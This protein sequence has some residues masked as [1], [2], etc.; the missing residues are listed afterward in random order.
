MRNACWELPQWRG[1]GSRSD[2]QHLRGKHLPC[3]CNTS[4]ALTASLHSDWSMWLASLACWL[5]VNCGYPLLT[6]TTYMSTDCRKCKCVPPQSIRLPQ[7]FLCQHSG[8]IFLNSCHS[9]LA[10]WQRYHGKFTY[11]Y[12]K[13]TCLR[14]D[15]VR[16]FSSEYWILNTDFEI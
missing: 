4:P 16:L 12:S 7:V 15:I 5:A 11:N 10:N 8:F 9:T 3:H 13:N 14:P 6:M 1:Q 2:E